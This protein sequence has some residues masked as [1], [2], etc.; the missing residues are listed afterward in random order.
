MEINLNEYLSI[1]EFYSQYIGL[2][3]CLARTLTWANLD[4][5]LEFKQIS[6]AENRILGLSESDLT[7]SM[8]LLSA[9][10]GEHLREHDVK[11]AKSRQ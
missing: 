6:H 4:N 11:D 5:F 3:R 9:G 2:V 8:K 7:S 10:H 1:E